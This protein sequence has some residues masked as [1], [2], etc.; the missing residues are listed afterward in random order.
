MLNKYGICKDCKTELQPVWFTQEE[1]KTEN[2]IMWKTG[3]KRKA[4]D[5]L[6]CPYC[7]RKECVDD[8]FDESWR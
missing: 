8:S 3:R 1:K 7:G 6:I 2:G 4:V 5:Y